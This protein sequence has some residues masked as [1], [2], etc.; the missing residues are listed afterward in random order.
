MTPA[1]GSRL[2]QVSTSF[3]SAG[4][5]LA[6]QH[7]L[8]ALVAQLQGELIP[9]GELSPGEA[10]ALRA[11]MTPLDALGRPRESREVRLRVLNERGLAFEHPAPLA[12]RRAWVLLES[13]RFGTVAA[14]I[15]L[16]WCRYNEGGRYTSGG[17]F[18]QFLSQAGQV[19]ELGLDRH[20]A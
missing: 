15:E 8:A 14:E 16:S 11:R 10:L 20:S 18:V 19:G 9:H 1:P 5:R 4:E 17:R 2:P 7:E 6:A 13:P 12:D 3:G